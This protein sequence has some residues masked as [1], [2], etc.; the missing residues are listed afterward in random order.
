MRAALILGTVFG[1][2]AVLALNLERGLEG[3]AQDDPAAPTS[4]SFSDG[5]ALYE[6][7]PQ[8]GSVPVNR[9]MGS[10]RSAKHQFNGLLKGRQSDVS[11]IFQSVPAPLISSPTFGCRLV[12]IQVMFSCVL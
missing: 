8:L 11:A 5:I 9:T 3:D 1:P 4:D 10:P 2:L 7:W 6:Q 12:W